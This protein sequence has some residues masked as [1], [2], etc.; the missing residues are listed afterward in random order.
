MTTGKTTS[1][2]EDTEA[3]PIPWFGPTL[4]EL[5]PGSPPGTR[6][7]VLR[8]KVGQ[9]LSEA[10]RDPDRCERI[11]RADHESRNAVAALVAEM[12]TPPLPRRDTEELP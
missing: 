10:Q 4:H 11:R 5:V 1:H 7:L 6:P 3:P 2:T 9:A 8:R 12:L